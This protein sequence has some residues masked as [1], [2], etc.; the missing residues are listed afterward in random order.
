MLQVLMGLPLKYQTGVMGPITAD[1]LQKIFI[2]VKQQRIKKQSS[3]SSGSSFAVSAENE[4][5]VRVEMAQIIQS[6]ER[7]LSLIKK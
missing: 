2:E 4:L 3:S 6:L 5:A 7:I 1:R